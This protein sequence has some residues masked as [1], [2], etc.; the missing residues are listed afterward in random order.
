MIRVSVDRSS[1]AGR[2]RTRTP[3][4]RG[5]AT[6]NYPERGLF[7]ASDL[8]GGRL[9]P[10]VAV[11]RG[12]CLAL[13]LGEPRAGRGVPFAS[14]HQTRPARHVGPRSR[15]W[16]WDRGDSA[17]RWGATVEHRTEMDFDAAG[18]ASLDR[19]AHPDHPAH[20]FSLGQWRSQPWPLSRERT[21]ASGSE[22][23]EN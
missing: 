11:T 6:S 16:L 8:G 21:V 9:T 3:T 5:R 22:R 19:S 14:N 10:I 23:C 15:R 17:E 20:L 13:K 12:R 2:R 18:G 1:S 7:H 4:F